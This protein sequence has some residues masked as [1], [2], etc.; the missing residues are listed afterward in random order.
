MTTPPT[1][2]HPKWLTTAA[3]WVSAVAALV[4]AGVALA[5]TA[6]DTTWKITGMVLAGLCLLAGVAVIIRGPR[7][8]LPMVLALVGVM[9]GSAVLGGLV[10]RPAAASGLRVTL[11]QPEAI[12]AGTGFRLTGTLSGDLP[13][14][15]LL[16]PA[17]QPDSDKSGF[18]S[19][20]R[21]CG[22]PDRNRA[23][24]CDFIVLARPGDWHVSLVL[25]SADDVSDYIGVRINVSDCEARLPSCRPGGNFLTRLRGEAVAGGSIAVRVP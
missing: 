3:P 17:V 1:S 6:D 9:I 16:W 18:Y 8:F 7:P 23:F 19:Q 13:P 24:V 4:S 12:R 5:A 15:T 10:A 25:A 21:N 20:G 22:T 11:Q 2:T 14:G